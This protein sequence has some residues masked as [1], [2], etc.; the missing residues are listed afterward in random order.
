MKTSKNLVLA[1]L[2]ATFINP[3]FAVKDDSAQPEASVPFTDPQTAVE[4]VSKAEPAPAKKMQKKQAAKPMAHKHAAKKHAAPK[5]EVPH[6]VQETSMTKVV[7]N[8]NNLEVNIIGEMTGVAAF[9]MNSGKAKDMQYGKGSKVVFGVDD[10]GIGVLAKGKA[11]VMNQPLEFGTKVTLTM[12]KYGDPNAGTTSVLKDSYVYFGNSEK[13]GLFYLGNLKGAEYRV[14]NTVTPVLGG[15]GSFMW[16]DWSPFINI[17]SGID[18][19]NLELTG[20][21]SRASKLLWASPVWRGLQATVSFTPNSRHFGFGAIQ[22]KSATALGA[23]TRTQLTTDSINSAITTY[24]M[25]QFAAGLSYKHMFH[26]GAT[27]QLAGSVLTG[28]TKAYITDPNSGVNNGYLL[29]NLNNYRRA[30]SYTLGAVGTYQNYEFGVQWIDNLKSA[31]PYN[32]SGRDA[33]KNIS[34]AVAYKMDIHKFALG[35]SHYQRK[36]GITPTGYQAINVFG[37]ANA[38]VAVPGVG[39]N[40]PLGKARYDGFTAVYTQHPVEGLRLFAEYGLLK[41]NTSNEYFKVAKAQNV[42]SAVPSQIAHGILTGLSI[43]F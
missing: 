33:G 43:N 12:D 18:T 19:T 3:A 8:D 20:K 9:P 24:Y 14:V 31:Q 37:G 27:A 35:Y 40:T 38:V 34:T 41:M 4:R 28:Q 22:N 5:A 13:Y 42:G 23:L 17:S 21:T 32:F 30:L 7:R 25:N 2:A 1:L 11:S 26:N 15:L 29:Q 6:T 16:N 39:G 10:T 36:L